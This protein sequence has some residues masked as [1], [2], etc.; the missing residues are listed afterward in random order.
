YPW[1]VRQRL[2]VLVG[3][4]PAPRQVEFQV[5][6]VRQPGRL[7]ELTQGLAGGQGQVEPAQVRKAEQRLALLSRTAQVDGQSLQHPAVEVVRV[8]PTRSRRQ[9]CRPLL[10]V[11]AKQVLG[12]V[13]EDGASGV[14]DRKVRHLALGADEG[15][16][17]R[18]AVLVEP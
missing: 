18:L 6:Q 4:V 2:E 1:A 14:S 8:E 5:R 3:N 11:Q 15:G 16:P 9:P 7:K 10:A 12:Q 17:R 13:V